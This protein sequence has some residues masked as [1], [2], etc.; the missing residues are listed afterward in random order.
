METLAQSLNREA[1]DG[2]AHLD[3]RREAR[4]FF[5]LTGRRAES[6]ALGGRRGEAC[7]HARIARSVDG[8]LRDAGQ[9]RS[10]SKRRMPRVEP[11]RSRARPTRA[12]VAVMAS[13]SLPIVIQWGWRG[14]G[15]RPPFEPPA[16]RAPEEVADGGAA[17]F[18]PCR[19]GVMPERRTAVVTARVSAAESATGL[20]PRRRRTPM[21][22]LPPTSHP[23]W[24]TSRLSGDPF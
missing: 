18:P 19:C 2:I 10:A 4:G 8:E 1:G 16:V 15:F 14:A 17:P 23:W 3:G 7:I 24:H 21:A 12:L 5:G 20:S 11:V 22:S 6:V 13:S 9:R